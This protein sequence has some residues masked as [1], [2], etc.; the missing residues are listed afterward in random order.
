MLSR[1]L[2]LMMCCQVLVCPALCIDCCASIDVC[3]QVQS[4]DS[5]D[6]CSSTCSESGKD[7]QSNAPCQ[8]GPCDPTSESC[9]CF[10]GGAVA[11]QAD[12]LFI[13]DASCWAF[14]DWF[15]SV[16]NLGSQLKLQLFKFNRE[17]EAKLY[18]RGLLRAHCVLLI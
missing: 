10:C 18:G 14:D 2:A 7:K 6:C 11:P 8:P 15:L 12:E 16:P 5:C 3:S 17:C 13:V 4:A 1:L 9:N